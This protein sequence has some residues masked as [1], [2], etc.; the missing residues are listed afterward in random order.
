VDDTSY[1]SYDSTSL[2]SGDMT[3]GSNDEST[4]GGS[5]AFDTEP[6]PP[7]GDGTPPFTPPN[8]G[9]GPAGPA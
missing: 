3:L 5:L 4:D 1:S 9:G 7:D 2:D 6:P 8:S